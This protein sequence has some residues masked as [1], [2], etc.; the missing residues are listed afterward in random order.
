MNKVLERQ[1]KK[2]FGNIESVP[3]ALYA[4]LKVVSDTYDNA[5]EDRRLI[6]HSLELSSKELGELN[7][8]LRKESETLKTNM[9]ETERMNKLMVDREL[10]MI[11]LKEELKLLKAQLPGNHAS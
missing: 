6:E 9:Q 11:E 8:N 4:F 5:E 10:K 3:Q 1:I 2:I 7:Q